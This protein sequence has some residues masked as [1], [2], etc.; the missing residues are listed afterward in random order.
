MT[1]VAHHTVTTIDG[2]SI[3]LSA[4]AGKVLLIVNTASKCGF[5]K[6]Y[7]DLQALHEEYAARG[8]AVLGFPCNDFGAQEPDDEATI[9][10]FCSL[11]YGVT[12]DM[13]SKLHA[14]GDDQHPLYAS[15]TETEDKEIGGAIRWNFTKF[16][17]N[18][19]GDVIAR[20]EPNI[21][22]NSAPVRDAIEAALPE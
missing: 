13:F 19:S 2:E 21:A 12:F 1:N 4:Y 18:G 16:L 8:L 9:K 10:S 15:L 17:V 6:Q 7:S 11:D 3:E 20:F 22:P 14:L 5:T